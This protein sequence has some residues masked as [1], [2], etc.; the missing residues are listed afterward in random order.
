MY[1]S[2]TDIRRLLKLKKLVITGTQ[3]RPFDANHQIGPCSVDVHISNEFWKFRD[4][5][6]IDVLNAYDI[7]RINKE[8][9]ALCEKIIL[10]PE[11]SIDIP[12]R[13][14]TLTHVLEYIEMPKFLAGIVT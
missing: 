14:V 12:P 5:Q 11:E 9:E 10:E 7:A 2:S 3:K 6:V 1:L 4:N 13:Q 8:P